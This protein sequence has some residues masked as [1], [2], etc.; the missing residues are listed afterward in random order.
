MPPLLMAPREAE[1]F[2][3][4]CLLML[5]L[6]PLEKSMVLNDLALVENSWVSLLSL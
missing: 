1:A 3:L 4:Q 5:I 6:I 2:I